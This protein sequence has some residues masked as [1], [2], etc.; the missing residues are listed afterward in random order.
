MGNCSSS[1]K[2]HPCSVLAQPLSG[3]L[4]EENLMEFVVPLSG[5]QLP[6][7]GLLSQAILKESM[8]VEIRLQYVIGFLLANFSVS[9][10][11]SI[12]LVFHCYA[13]LHP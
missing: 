6:L 11:L 5:K 4:D 1:T 7:A 13:F 9:V 12:L 2:T 8:S 3:S 10:A